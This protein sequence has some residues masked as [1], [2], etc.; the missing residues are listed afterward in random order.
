M[1][2]DLRSNDRNMGDYRRDPACAWGVLHL[3]YHLADTSAD[4]AETDVRNGGNRSFF[5]ASSRGDVYHI[6]WRRRLTNRI[7]QEKS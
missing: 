2:R 1:R 3:D 4:I 7:S 6:G 5:D